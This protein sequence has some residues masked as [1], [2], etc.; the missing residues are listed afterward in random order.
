MRIN[1]ELSD[2]LTATVK[3]LAKKRDSSISEVIRRAISLENFFDQ[4]LAEGTKVLLKSKDS[5][6]L[7]EVILR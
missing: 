6:N 1:I 7:Q 3:E 4:E 2:E 5:D